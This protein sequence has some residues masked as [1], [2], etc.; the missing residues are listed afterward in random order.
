MSKKDDIFSKYMYVACMIEDLES[1]LSKGMSLKRTGELVENQE[2]V[3]SYEEFN[4][5]SGDYAFPFN[6]TYVGILKIPYDYYG[7]TKE[8]PTTMM[9]F[10]KSDFDYKNGFRDYVIPNLIFGILNTETKKFMENPLYNPIFDPTGLQFCFSQI[11][12]MKNLGSKRVRYLSGWKTEYDPCSIRMAEAAEA[13]RAI[14]YELLKIQDEI[15]DVFG[16]IIEHYNSLR[17]EEYIKNIKR[18]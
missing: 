9:P 8:N 7:G 1:F 18:L 10:I 4:W 13:R 6:S 17:R 2:T 5:E 15:G 16:P 3:I 14:P 11:N 12:T